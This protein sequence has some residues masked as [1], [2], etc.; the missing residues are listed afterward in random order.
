MHSL[1]TIIIDATK[2]NKQSLE[3]DDSKKEDFLK[4]LEDIACLNDVSSQ[5]SMK[6]S[7]KNKLYQ[8]D[9]KKLS[10][11]IYE[12]FPLSDEEGEISEEKSKEEEKGSK[13]EKPEP[14]SDI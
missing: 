4:S 1:L 12:D 14:I 8:K 13:S 7:T 11:E 10:L 6:N 5:F 3:F 2:K 9:I